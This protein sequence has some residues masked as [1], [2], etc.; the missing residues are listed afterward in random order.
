MKLPA[1]QQGYNL[2]AVP[3]D[4]TVQALGFENQQSFIDSLLNY[5]NAFDPGQSDIKSVNQDYHD[6]INAAVKV[7][8]E[9]SNVYSAAPE[10]PT[11]PINPIRIGLFLVGIFLIYKIIKK[12]K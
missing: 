12:R 1:Q 6:T 7:K 2:I 4:P 8:D 9:L 3:D 5:Q 10:I 11:Q